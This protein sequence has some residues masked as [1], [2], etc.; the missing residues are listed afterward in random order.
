MRLKYLQKDRCILAAFVAV[1]YCMLIHDEFFREFL[2]NLFLYFNSSIL[3]TL[4]G[5]IFTLWLTKKT[6]K[7]KLK[8]NIKLILFSSFCA[9]M[10]HVI[11][12]IAAIVILTLISRLVSRTTV[13]FP[14]QIV[15]DAVILTVFFFS[16]LICLQK[17]FGSPKVKKSSMKIE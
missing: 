12:G 16:T 15:A 7:A 5:I 6:F 17:I 14:W 10:N 9:C 8:K 2:S 11:A 3:P 13:V 1:I 4:I